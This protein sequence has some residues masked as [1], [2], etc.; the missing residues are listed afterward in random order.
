MK[1]LHLI[2]ENELMCLI[3]MKNQQK[4]ASH[5]KSIEHKILR[6]VTE[7]A[8][9]T[10]RRLIQLQQG[11]QRK[12]EFTLETYFR[13]NFFLNVAYLINLRKAR[14]DYET[15]SVSMVLKYIQNMFGSS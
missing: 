13:L 9:L 2:L 8:C 1:L 14:T 11:E 12:P 3:V 7:Q 5:S 6:E 10:A 15:V 4:E